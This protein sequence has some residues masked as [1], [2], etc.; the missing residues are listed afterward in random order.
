MKS[1]LA[2]RIK[3]SW[4]K[5]DQKD[6]FYYIET[7]N[8]DGDIDRFF[9]LGEQRAKILIDPMLS[10]LAINAAD[11]TALDLGCGVGRFSRPLS[12]R[13]AS[14][15]G[16]DVSDEMIRRAKEVNRTWPKPIEFRVGDGLVLPVDKGAVDFAFSYEVFQHFPSVQSVLDGFKEIRRVLHSN[17]YGLIHW[18]TSDLSRP[19]WRNL[20]TRIPQPLTGWLAQ[21][22]GKDPLMIDPAFRGTAVSEEAIPGICSE[23]GLSIV[24]VLG[25]TTHAPGTRAFV[26]VQPSNGN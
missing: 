5:R 24:G 10:Q 3:E 18:K 21:L 17:G 16:V 15:I 26:S 8:W 1:D 22:A 6:P 11:K 25:D 9:V 23:A 12:D 13:F 2:L 7:E 20:G 14:E 4:N 19:L